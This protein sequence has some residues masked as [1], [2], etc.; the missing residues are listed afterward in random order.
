MT[1][2]TCSEKPCSEL[3]DKTAD[4]PACQEQNAHL[5]VMFQNTK[6][7]DLWGKNNTN[8]RDKKE[9]Y[10]NT[11]VLKL[12]RK[13]MTHTS[14][15]ISRPASPSPELRHV[16]VKDLKAGE[17]EHDKSW[18]WTKPNKKRTGETEGVQP[19]RREAS[20]ETPF[21]DK[22]EECIFPYLFTT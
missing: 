17:P 5:F 20:P 9:W 4:Y 7:V 16:V 18:T 12:K 10:G 15:T 13:K 8:V 2:H 11:N 14:R 1:Q 21:R 3:E 6:Q 22:W 19:S